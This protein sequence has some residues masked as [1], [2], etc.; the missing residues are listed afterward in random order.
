VPL[1]SDEELTR[2]PL[3]ELDLQNLP[4]LVLALLLLPSLLLS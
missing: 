3:G 4:D 1:P 2:L